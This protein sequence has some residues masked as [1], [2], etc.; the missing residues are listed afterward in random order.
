MPDTIQAAREQVAALRVAHA[1]SLAETQRQP[2]I[3]RLYRGRQ[4]LNSYGIRFELDPPTLDV[5][6]GDGSALHHVF[7]E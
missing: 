1:K 3:Y 4:P 2:R 7:Q 6:G 5:P